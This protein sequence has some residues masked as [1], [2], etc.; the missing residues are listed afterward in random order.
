MSLDPRLSIM[1]QPLRPFHWELEFPEVF[2]GSTAGFD[3][4]FG[5]PPFLGGSR[6]STAFGDAYLDWLLDIFQG[7]QG[8]CDLVAYFFR[9]AF[10]LIKR[11]G[12]IGFVAT[13]TVSQ[14]DTRESGLAY[15]LSR[16]AHIFRAV[17]R[18][19]WPGEAAVVV[20][21]VHLLKGEA[22][23]E[24]LLDGYPCSRI[25]AYLVDGILDGSPLALAENHGKS[26]KG[27]YVLGLGFTFD[28][29]AA[30]RGQAW[31][32]SKMREIEAEYPAEAQRIFP[33]LGGV[34]LNGDPEHRHRRFVIDLGDINEEDAWQK[35]PQLMSM[36]KERVYP[37]R[38]Q[39]KRESNRKYWWRFSERQPAMLRAIAPLRRIIGI[40][41][42]TPH[43][44]FTFLNK[45][46]V[47][48][49]KVIVIA[50]E[51]AAAL[52]VLSSR[53]SEIW[54]RSFTSTMKDDLNYS[55]SDCFE[56]FPMPHNMSS[57]ATLEAVGAVYYEHRAA[58]MIAR[59][60]GLT[61]IY[62]RFHNS[63]E[64]GLDIARLR[65]LHHALDQA[66]LRA[67]DWADLANRATP[68]FLRD[69]T[70]AD[71]RYQGRLFWPASFR[72]EVQARLLALNADRHRVEVAS[73]LAPASAPRGR[74][75]EEELI[76]VLETDA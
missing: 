2:L 67:Y 54:I 7:A 72:D 55:P 71:H 17:R 40:A 59:N 32:L 38:K 4:I 26:Y 42:V 70:E 76:V 28:D 21:V 63:S 57:D 6:I 61:K 52:A 68:E 29:Y 33:Y 62:N 5:N 74:D 25:S 15:L 51:S 9:R 48:N 10:D 31:P 64:R 22:P 18:L 30:E 19:S 65:E 37:Q 69:E 27:S 1:H 44:A 11:G 60:E 36:L 34:D 66:V 49:E 41:R 24:I 35:W 75:Q 13:N 47:Y 50:Y 56:N 8:K 58:L 43:A 16:E 53:A 3:A 12:A 46:I 73:G 39:D 14:G 23:G 45:G 20:S